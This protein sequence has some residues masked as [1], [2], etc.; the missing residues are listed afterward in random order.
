MFSPRWEPIST[1]QRLFRMSVRSG[2]PDFLAEGQVEPDVARAAALREGRRGD[3]RRAV[4]LQRVLEEV[5]AEA[6]REERHRLGA[7]AR[8]DGLQL[9]GDVAEGL[10]PG[11]LRPDVLAPLLPADER[12]L[13]PVVVEVGADAARAARAEAAAASAGRP[14]CPRSSRACRPGRRRWP[15]T[16]RSRC[17]RRWGSSGGRTAAPAAAAPARPASRRR[18]RPPS[19]RWWRRNPQESTSGEGIH[20]AS[21]SSAPPRGRE[22]EAGRH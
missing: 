13:Q 14:G 21:R 16:S 18:P 15:R 12:R 5:A 22:L 2:R 17:R 9:L 11:D 6:V 7:V 8:L 4:G 19:P 20:A 10:V 1:R 3:V